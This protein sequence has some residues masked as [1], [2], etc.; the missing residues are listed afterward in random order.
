MLRP[1]LRRARELMP[2]MPLACLAQTRSERL[3][4]SAGVHVLRCPLP[5]HAAAHAVAAAKI[6]VCEAVSRVVDNGGGTLRSH[7]RLQVKMERDGAH[8]ALLRPL[9]DRVTSALRQHHP[10]F[11]ERLRLAMI[12]D[13][14]GRDSV[15]FHLLHFDVSGRAPRTPRQRLHLDVPLTWRQRAGAN[16][17]AHMPF[18]LLVPITGVA[19]LNVSGR[20]VS[21]ADDRSRPSENVRVTASRGDVLVCCGDLKHGGAGNTT[22]QRRL[23]LHIAVVPRFMGA[24][25]DVSFTRLRDDRAL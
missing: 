25:L 5:Q 10:V 20:V 22:R 13:A 1:V 19:G 14:V 17:L 12:R 8:L 3:L 6:V 24:Q 7:R 11:A 23:R 16:A 15:E 4:L 18:F 21:M 9:V 2:N